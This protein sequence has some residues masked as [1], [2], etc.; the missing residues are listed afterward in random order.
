MNKDVIVIG[1]GAAGSAALRAAARRGL[2]CL[3]I[4]QF[5]IAH[6]RGSSHGRSRLFRS[7]SSEG[8]EYVDL[9]ARSRRLWGEL[10]QETGEEI[11]TV[12]GGL[13][14][15]SADSPLLADVRRAMD[16]R[17]L[18]YE[19]LDADDLRRRYPQHRIDDSDTG[20]L[21]PGTGVVRPELAIR[22]SVDAARAAGA[23][24]R[25][26]VSATHITERSG[27]VDVRLSDGTTVSAAQVVVAAGAWTALL[28][29]D[30]P[31]PLTVRRAVLSWFRPRPGAED[32][33][34]ADVFPVFTREN[35]G[36]VSGWGAPIIDE[37]GVKIGLH[38]QAG[39]EIDDPAVNDP[40]V[41]PWELERVHAFCAEQFADLEP[42]AQHPRGCMI[43]LT[44]DERFAVG[45]VDPRS[46]IVTLAACSGH[47]FKH[48]AAVGELGVQIALD[49]Q[50]FID[51]APFDPTRYT[52]Q[53]EA[54]Q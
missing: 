13:T 53:K 15:A 45:R 31:V 38:D 32:R 46:R 23:E 52:R 50:P 28:Q 54:V 29:P 24:V 10:E 40:R 11:V 17:S 37:Y 44:P 18:P 21:D 5:E 7:G 14:I 51:P 6:D 33:F 27:G 22:L 43:T 25:T 1:L 19:V 8:A 35:S 42:V 34:A 9:A 30:Y 36:E 2:D 12:V 41:A 26:G 48:S 16:A 20:V 39:Y 3:G 47:G 4:E 49:E